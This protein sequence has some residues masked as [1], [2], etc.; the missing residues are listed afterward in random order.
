MEI[1]CTRSATQLKD[2]EN[3]Y[4][5]AFGRELRKDLELCHHVHDKKLL[6]K[7]CEAPLLEGS[8]HD[9]QQEEQVH[10]AS[11]NVCSRRQ[12]TNRDPNVALTSTTLLVGNEAFQRQRRI[13][14]ELV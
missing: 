8:R 2:A 11:L 5:T 3:A 4:K 1:L 6:L 10:N 7:L 9:S 13:S 14:A 12:P